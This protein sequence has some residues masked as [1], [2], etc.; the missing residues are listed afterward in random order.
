MSSQTVDNRTECLVYGFIRMIDVKDQIIPSSIINL[1]IEFYYTI[2]TIICLKG[3]WTKVPT[4]NITELHSKKQYKC[5]VKPLYD[6]LKDD[7]TKYVDQNSGLCF[8]KDFKLPQ[9]LTYYHDKLN[10]KKMYDVKFSIGG[11]MS[12]AHNTAY[13]IDKYNVNSINTEHVT[14][15][16]YWRLPSFSECTEIRYSLYSYKYGLIAIGNCNN[17]QKGLNML[18]FKE[19]KNNQDDWK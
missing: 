18:K 5:T 19:Y 16:Y 8:V 9:K 7:N 10:G 6:S 13:I 4:I 2:L 14:N 11:F 15:I 12:T 17:K 1:C 3:I